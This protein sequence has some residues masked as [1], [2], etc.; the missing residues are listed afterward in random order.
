MLLLLH[1]I[2]LM[3]L[4]RS[5]RLAQLMGYL[6]QLARRYR[7]RRFAR[8]VLRPCAFLRGSAR[9]HPTNSD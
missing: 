4:M 7:A 6:G 2:Q 9:A 8:L 1:A 5:C 3:L